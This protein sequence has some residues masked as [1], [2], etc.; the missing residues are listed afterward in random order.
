MAWWDWGF[1][2]LAAAAGGLLVASYLAAPGSGR[3]LETGCSPCASAAAATLPLALMARAAGPDNAGMAVL[4][5][6]LIATGVRQ[7]VSGGTSCD[8]RP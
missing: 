6:A 3:L 1:V 7:R 2:L 4:A 8:V 5:L